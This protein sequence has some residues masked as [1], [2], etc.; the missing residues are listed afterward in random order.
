MQFSRYSTHRVDVFTG[1][2]LFGVL[3]CIFCIFPASRSAR[4]S[5]SQSSTGPERWKQEAAGG[6]GTNS[7]SGCFRLQCLIDTSVDHSEV[8]QKPNPAQGEHVSS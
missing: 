8:V 1:F 3:I 7:G 2:T 5:D 4:R 6:T